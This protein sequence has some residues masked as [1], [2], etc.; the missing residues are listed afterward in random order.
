MKNW[1]KSVA[2]I[3]L[4]TNLVIFAAWLSYVPRIMN[5]TSERQYLFKV[6]V[7]IYSFLSACLL[8]ILGVLELHSVRRR[9]K[10]S[11]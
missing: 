3:L 1:R 2:A 4:V 9:E 8:A 5:W 7:I 11:E 10:E 6:A